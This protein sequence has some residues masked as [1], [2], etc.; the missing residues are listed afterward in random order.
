MGLKERSKCGN[1]MTKTLETW[2]WTILQVLMS[3]GTQLI[4]TIVESGSA[5]GFILNVRRWSD[6]LRHANL[7]FQALPSDS[8]NDPDTILIFLVGTRIE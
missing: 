5:D 2:F 6:N 8:L 1:L 7:L 3:A 4:D